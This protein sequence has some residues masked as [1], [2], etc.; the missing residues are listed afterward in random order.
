MFTG[1]KPLPGQ[2]ITTVI[3][4]IVNEE[5]T[6]PRD[7]DSSIHPGL[8]DIIMKSLSKEPASRYQSCRELF[9]DLRNYRSLPSA[10]NPNTTLPTAGASQNNQSQGGYLDNSQLATT[11]RS[12]ASRASHP[13]QTP[14]VRRTGTT[15]P[16]PEPNQG[17]V[18]ATVLAAIF[19]LAVIA[20]GAQKIR[21]VF[22]AARQQS[23]SPEASSETSVPESAAAN[24]VT[25]TTTT[26]TPPA[27]IPSAISPSANPAPSP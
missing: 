16:P 5:P 10:F 26:S 21:P 13:L 8:N 15:T 7:I 23:R 3:Y 12:L 24:P 18:L 2:N 27:N 22:Q 4:K 11:S 9:E 1:E 19:L 25:S 20:F 17:N 14:V 6:A